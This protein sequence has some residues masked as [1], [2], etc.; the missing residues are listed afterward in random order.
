MI[1]KVIVLL[2]VTLTGITADEAGCKYA[3]FTPQHSFCTPRN[4][5]CEIVEAG[6]NQEDKDLLLKLHNDYRSKVALGQE[7][8]AGGLPTAANMLEMVRIHTF[9]AFLFL[10]YSK[11]I[12]GGENNLSDITKF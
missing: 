10:V 5:Q 11:K 4:P 3:K 8:R 6:L 7:T 2:A 12:M 9:T 1:F